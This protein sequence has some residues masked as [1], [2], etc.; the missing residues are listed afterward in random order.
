M[1]IISIISQCDRVWSKCVVLYSNDY[2]V[3]HSSVI[4]I[5]KVNEISQRLASILLENT[6]F[7]AE[8]ENLNLDQ[9]AGML[10]FQELL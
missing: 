7:L 2:K 1:A 3:E 4:L 8:C 5:S 9:R 10:S 6:Y